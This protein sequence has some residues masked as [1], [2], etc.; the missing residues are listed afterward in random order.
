MDQAR[1]NS[2]I[3][4]LIYMFLDSLEALRALNYVAVKLN[5][6]KRTRLPYSLSFNSQIGY[7]A[8]RRSWAH[9]QWTYT[10]VVE[11]L[12]SERIFLPP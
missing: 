10:G 6:V 5:T 11:I 12:L 2:T 4:E 3:G 8:K 1:I 9:Q 7:I